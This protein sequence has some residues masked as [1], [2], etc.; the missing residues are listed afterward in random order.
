MMRGFILVP[1]V[2]F[3][4]CC[5]LFSLAKADLVQQREN[6]LKAEKALEQGHQ[7]D[8]NRLASTLTDYPL[9][10]YL[11]YWHLKQDI[12]LEREQEIL[13]FL[14]EFSETPLAGKLRSEWLQYLANNRHWERL[15]RDYQGSAREK[16]QCAR[17][18][19]LLETGKR[20]QA[21]DQAENLWLHGKSR[22]D[23]CDPL[24]EAWRQAD[25]LTP[26]LAWERIYL[27]M[28]QDRLNLANYLKKYLPEQDRTILEQWLRIARDPQQTTQKNWFRMEHPAREKMLVHGMKKLIRK[29]TPYATERWDGLRKEYGWSRSDFPEIE[30]DIALYLAFR[31]HDQALERF[32][33]MP[34]Q[35]KDAR[36]RKWHVRTALYQLDW[37]ELLQAW[38]HLTD[39]QQASMKWQY[40]RARALEEL[41]HASQAAGTY[42][43]LLGKQNYFSLL[44]ADRLQRPYLFPHETLLADTEKIQKLLREPGIQRALELFYL[45]RTIDA[46]REW[47][48]ALQ[49]K[50][51]GQLATA[52]VLAH[53]LGWN[54]R[55]IHAA[56]QAN[57]FQDLRLRF[58]LSF[59]DL[60]LEHARNKDLDPAWI[61]A[62]ARQES[63]FMP[64]IKSPAGALGVMQIMPG[65]GRTIASKL[66]ESWN[67]PYPLLRPETSIRFG[68]FYLNLRLNELQQNPVLATAAYNAGINKIRD[69]LPETG[70]L[71]AD[72]WVETL[73]YR[74]TRNYVERVFAY[75]AIYQ[76]RMNQIPTRLSERMPDIPPMLGPSEMADAEESY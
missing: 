75:T 13:D 24:F 33:N 49:D 54:D 22:P 67:N 55:A 18:K 50:N 34:E 71:P 52:A 43:N 8:F 68:T 59:Q 66:N 72:V 36:T 35:I 7:E 6:F 11:V 1:A 20:E 14:E 26:N 73:P 47:L 12:S 69:W 10:P 15:I 46:R 45:E 21:W 4:L 30:R 51:S 27:V 2:C 3:L 17:G 16:V 44:A 37:E 38:R 29:D 53:D 40:W 56:A 74:E 62:L 76:A 19:A 9:Y 31:R 63:M 61:L 32:D 23:K 60:F 28:D 42:L 25:K 65:T 70:T 5:F 48:T 58:P 41:G 39:A 64:E 57:E